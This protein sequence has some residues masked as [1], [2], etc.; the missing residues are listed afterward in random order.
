MVDLNFVAR[1][2]VPV[3]CFIFWNYIW[4][5]WPVAAQQ[6]IVPSDAL[7]VGSDLNSTWALLGEA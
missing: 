3:L 5:Q 6:N 7:L 4:G 2:D 1:R